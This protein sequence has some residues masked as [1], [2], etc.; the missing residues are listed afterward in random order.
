[1]L[2]DHTRDD[3]DAA[4]VEQQSNLWETSAKQ[5][6][7]AAN[8]FVNK[9]LKKFPVS[10]TGGGNAASGKNAANTVGDPS[11]EPEWK[12]GELYARA[13]LALRD[14]NVQQCEQLQ[15]EADKVRGDAHWH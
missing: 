8:S 15:K 1:M 6:E 3:G 5:C 13:A 11:R 7:R 2:N 14:G 12:A 4:L 9:I 10:I